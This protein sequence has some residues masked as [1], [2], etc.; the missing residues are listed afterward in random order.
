MSLKKL[1][2]LNPDGSVATTQDGY[3]PSSYA[4]TSYGKETFISDTDLGDVYITVSASQPLNGRETLEEFTDRTVTTTNNFK[5]NPL[6]EQAVRGQI[7]GVFTTGEAVFQST[8]TPTIVNNYVV[9]GETLSTFVPEIGSIGVSGEIGIRAGQFKGTYND[10]A[11]QKA[12]GI[13]LPAFTTS[14]STPYF[15][16]EGWMYLEQEPSNNYDPI[17]ITRS[18]DGVNNSTN[19][20]FRLEYD[21]SSDQVQ[22]HYADSSY[23]SAGYRGIVNVSPAG[24]C[25]GQWNHFAIAWASRGGS[26]SV[27]TYWNGTSLYSAAGL[28]GYIRNSTAPLMIGSGASGDYP[29][30]GWLEDIHIRMGGETLALADYTFLGSTAPNE[31]DQDYA[32]DYTVYLMSMNAPVGSTYFPVDNLCRVVGNVTYNGSEYGVLGVGNI[33]RAETSVLGL[34]L[35]GGVCGGFTA[36]GGSGGVLYGTKSGACMVISSVDQLVGLSAAQNQRINGAQHTNY[37]LFGITVMAGISGASGDFPRLFSSGWS[38]TAYSFLPTQSNINWLRNLYDSVVVSG[39]TGN[40]LIEDY[41][42][43]M[44]S[45]GTTYVQKLYQDV[46]AYR[47]DANT[48]RTSLV[49]QIKATSTLQS[50]KTV[51]G[52]SLSIILKIAPYADESSALAIPP[53][54]KITKST[55]IPESKYLSKNTNVPIQDPMP[56]EEG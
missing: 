37:F 55:S 43:T 53:K 16:V 40:T 38:G 26:A 9:A 47:G 12:A 15:L 51:E 17:I 7:T 18:A 29:L 41:Y 28:C 36:T 54:A 24:V 2:T 13:R 30:K 11:A 1:I 10:T 6:T 35:F 33:V 20:S 56:Y 45:F 44:N 42:G 3:D 22:F 27:K 34:S 52:A 21:T 19:D 14:T 23:A 46:V 48:L 5:I 32:G 49:K 50:L 31:Y 8:I 4:P 39:Y 25:T